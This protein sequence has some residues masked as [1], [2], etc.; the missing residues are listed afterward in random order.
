MAE[1][2]IASRRLWVGRHYGKAAS[3][4][5]QVSRSV[6]QATSR[7]ECLNLFDD[8][9]GGKQT[10]CP[11]KLD[12][13]KKD[14]VLPLVIGFEPHFYNLTLQITTPRKTEKNT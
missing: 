2:R 11:K 13:G 3:R 7:Y 12:N 4:P 8:A 14:I 5:S 10:K 1:E 6:A 9:C